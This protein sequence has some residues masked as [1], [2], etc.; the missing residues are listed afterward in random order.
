MAEYIGDQL[1]DLIVA[2]LEYITVARDG[3]DTVLASVVR[4]TAHQEPAENHLD[5]EVLMLWPPDEDED[6]STP[7]NPPI[8]GWVQ[9][10]QVSVVVN[11]SETDRTTPI[12]T[13]FARV[14][15]DCLRAMMQDPA[16]PGVYEPYFGG[17]ANS[18]SITTPEAFD[19]GASGVSGL[20]LGIRVTF[21][22][23]ETNISLQPGA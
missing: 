1:A 17:L 16:S 22:L 19:G 14:A 15:R 11:P 13:F 2:R 23:L 18:T 8:I 6:L 4:P 21:Q 12:D 20:N 10:F 5:A 7:S 9:E 3:Y